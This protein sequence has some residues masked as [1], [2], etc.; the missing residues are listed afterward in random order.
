LPRGRIN[1]GL[2]LD[3]SPYVGRFGFD[4]Q[5]TQLPNVPQGYPA[6]VAAEQNLHNGQ[7]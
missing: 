4:F 5:F 3:I 7:N 1:Q 2:L 6:L